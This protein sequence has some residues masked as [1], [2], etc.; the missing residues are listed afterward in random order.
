VVR[1]GESRVG[2]ANSLGPPFRRYSSNLV[3]GKFS[4]VGLPLYGVLGR[5]HAQEDPPVPHFRRSAAYQTT[6]WSFQRILPR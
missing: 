5:A 2:A 6:S 3:E 1:S 4:E